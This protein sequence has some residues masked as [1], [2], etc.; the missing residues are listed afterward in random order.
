MGLP[1]DV[2]WWSRALGVI[3]GAAITAVG[4][5]AALGVLQLRRPERPGTAAAVG[6]LAAVLVLLAIITKLVRGLTR[7]DRE[8][9]RLVAALRERQD[10]TDTLLQSINEGVVVLD[11]DRRVM[12]VNSRWQQMT[13][14][15]AE[16]ARGT[17]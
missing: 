12:D 2:W 17:L 11:A 14:R 4:A 9:R 6:A 16:D 8:Q 3:A 15:R 7:S 1:R 5:A 13:G 10:F